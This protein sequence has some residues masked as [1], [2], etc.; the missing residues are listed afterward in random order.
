LVGEKK[1]IIVDKEICIGCGSCVADCIFLS[2]SLRDGKAEYSGECLHCGH[3]VAICPADAVTIPEYDMADVEAA[4]SGLI[5]AQDLLSVIKS[6]RSIRYYQN[7]KI[8]QEKLEN[9]VQ[10]GRYTATGANRQACR[11]ILVKDELEVL[12]EL[13]WS[14]VEKVVA[15]STEEAQPLKGLWALRAAQG[16]DYLFR[17][18]PA[19]L[20]IATENLWDAGMAAQNMELAAVSQ[21]LGVLYNGFLLRSTGLSEEAC[22]LLR[23]DGKPLATCMLLGY[24]DVT[25]HRTAPRK[26]ADVV[27]L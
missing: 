8:E 3:C 20:Y 10:A 22:R 4:R 13:I 26:K 14:S 5:S 25:Y 7:K 17:N 27:W 2:L 15:T 19:V 21:G 12:K 24:P 16:I 1:M 23:L 18:A 9:I 11:F 6:R